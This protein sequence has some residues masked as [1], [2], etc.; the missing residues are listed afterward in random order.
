MSRSQTRQPTPPPPIRTGSSGKL[1]QLVKQGGML[2]GVAIVGAAIAVL[3]N[4]R[5]TP[6]P[7]PAATN[8]VPPLPQAPP[9]SSA[10]HPSGPG[11]QPDL[12]RVQSE[13]RDV[14]QEIRDLK[15]ARDK[16]QRDTDRLR[17]EQET[18]IQEGEKLK[19]EIRS[20]SAMRDTLQGFQTSDL[21][22][23]APEV[24]GVALVS[25]QGEY[26]VVSVANGDLAPVAEKISAK[27]LVPR[28]IDIRLTTRLA[29]EVRV[30]SSLPAHFVQDLSNHL[31]SGPY[32]TTPDSRYVAF[33]DLQ[34]AE[35]KLGFLVSADDHQAVVLSSDGK[36]RTVRSTQVRP[37]SAMIGS[38]KDLMEIAG[39][40]NYLD[41]V[42]LRIADYF[43]DPRFTGERVCLAVYVSTDID[44]IQQELQKVESH[45]ASGLERS[46]TIFDVPVQAYFVSRARDLGKR[47]NVQQGAELFARKAEDMLYSRLVGMGMH[48]VERQN[49]GKV[50][51]EAGK[52]AIVH[53]DFSNFATTFASHAYATHVVFL[54]VG[55]RHANGDYHLAARLVDCAKGGEVLWADDSESYLSPP[56]PPG[57][58]QD[59][60][61]QLAML[62]SPA[63][64]GRPSVSRNIKVPLH[65]P[66]QPERI[67]H[68]MPALSSKRNVV[69]RE[70]FDRQLYRIPAGD[71][72]ILNENLSGIDDAK[73][74]NQ[75]RYLIWR[76]A[77]QA[78]PSA[79]RVVRIDQSAS[80]ATVSLS[81]A[82][83]LYKEGDTFYAL[84]VPE[85]DL[86]YADNAH[87]AESQLEERLPFHLVASH[88]QGD[89]FTLQ[90]N[91]P[92]VEMLWS[93]GYDLE[94]GDVAQPRYYV[95]P[96]VG[97]VIGYENPIQQDQHKLNW[98]RPAR[99]QRIVT[100]TR[101]TGQSLVSSLRTALQLVDV[102]VDIE[103]RSPGSR[104][105]HNVNIVLQP[106]Y[107]DDNYLVQVQLG[108]S[109]TSSDVTNLRFAV[110]GDEIRDWSP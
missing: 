18:L 76:I 35:T 104:N 87:V 84:R 43:S 47:R 91:A 82:S 27:C 90:I 79:G 59:N 14:K 100:Q 23:L 63:S 75:L 71:F 61:G 89:E 97:V 36:S 10:G 3:V 8:Q 109:G 46:A 66:N 78:L 83:Q 99:R 16:V 105:T 96:R 51:L 50:L 42:S 11:Y 22:L 20:L 103:Q 74:G 45:L 4:G 52:R 70:L 98:N 81:K 64:A 106:T 26:R 88:I 60:S 32:R 85:L 41:F 7:A 77:Q 54:D 107:P 72:E 15:S 6:E 12:A 102:D 19:K 17:R 80:S 67:V 33:H 1:V 92:N 48:V 55:T 38:P 25:D 86:K 95:S 69:I 65:A 40:I 53:R 9:P 28:I 56:V 58:W 31:V 68:Y 94:L 21:V 49:L 93:N 30:N 13:L 37:G 108:S 44:G 57:S 34:A 5:R 101:E 73:F 39:D 29:R 2:L 62:R 110:R 24:S